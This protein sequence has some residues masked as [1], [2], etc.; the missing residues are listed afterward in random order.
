MRT[1]RRLGFTDEYLKQFGESCKW[2]SVQDMENLAWSH[3]GCLKEKSTDLNNA[4]GCLGNSGVQSLSSTSTASFG[5]PEGQFDSPSYQSL[6]PYSG[7][8]RHDVETGE[9]CLKLEGEDF[10]DKLRE[11]ESEMF[12]PDVRTLDF[13]ECAFYGGPEQSLM[14][15]EKF[16]ILMQMISS[17]DLRGVLIACAKAIS[18]ND[19]KTTEWLMSHLNHMV[20]VSGEPIQRLGAYMLEGLIARLSASGSSIYKSLGC[21]EAIAGSELLSYMHLMYELCPYIKFGYMSANGAIAD[22]MRDENRIHIIDFQISQGSQWFPIIQALSAQPSGPPH[23]RITGID[24]P[25]SSYARGGGLSIVANRLS[26]FA[27]SCKVPFEFCGLN[28]PGAEIDYQSLGIR[29]GE[30]IAVNFAFTLHHMPDESV[31]TQNHRDR[32]LRL[33]KSLS[34]KVVTLIEQESNTNTSPFFPRFIET[35]DY[36]TAIFESIDETLPRNHINRIN[37]EQHCLARDIVNIL[38]CEGAERVERHELLGKW[39]S[40]FNM[41]GFWPYP[42]SSVV[43]ET[44][45]NLLRKYCEKYRLEERDGALYLGWRNRALVASSAWR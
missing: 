43:N 39:N 25:V 17:G 8:N 3:D 44:I 35:L 10:S 2:D 13:P 23:I 19:M 38:A 22:A 18:E 31:G 5:S 27:E 40:R 21:K 24:D 12:G 14:Q 30:A 11:L 29:Q 1:S 45:K 41:A 16:R 4:E 7:E 34:P 6:M 36:Y 15:T 26:N 20:S 42:L 9:A 33:V 32:L 37:V 28:L